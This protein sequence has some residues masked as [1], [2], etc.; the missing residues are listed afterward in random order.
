MN[1]A[2]LLSNRS[3]SWLELQRLTNGQGRHGKGLTAQDYMELG[4]LYRQACADAARARS[5]GV[6]EV[7]LA[8]LDTLLARSHHL[9]YQAPP[10]AP[11]AFR[12]LLQVR[13]PQAVRANARL[14]AAANLVFYGPFFFGLLVP[15]LLP[16]FA[17]ALLGADQVEQFRDMY[18]KINDEGRTLGSGSA[19]V[20]YYIQHNITIAFE[21]FACGIF[22]GL[23]SLFMLS[24]QGLVLGTVHGLLIADGKGMNLLTFVCGHGPWE[25]TAIVLAGLGGMRMGLA[26]VDT[27]GRTRMG[28]LRAARQ[29]IA[30]I[31]LGAAA[32][33]TI[34]ATLEGLWSPS[35]AP[36]WA[37]WLMS[38]VQI[39]CVIGYLAR[40]GLSRNLRS[41]LDVSPRRP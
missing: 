1:Q 4:Q 29:D 6:D 12:H 40:S 17:S 3:K 27:Q 32:M 13:F 24:Y 38:I 34:A 28:S 10:A 26:W 35:Q 16:G 37:K 36:P 30:A 8:Y 15:L 39:A 18:S 33:L 20:S 2:D 22:A 14:F 25:L 31:I 5:A 19:A 23:G 7:T 9:F 21:V 11:G 41:G